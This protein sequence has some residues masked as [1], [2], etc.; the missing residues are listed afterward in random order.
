MLMIAYMKRHEPAYRFA[1]RM[2]TNVVFGNKVR[3]THD[4]HAE[5]LD[6]Y[7][8]G[9]LN[10][11]CSARRTWSTVTTPRSTPSPSRMRLT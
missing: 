2:Q 5:M 8:A 10:A 6:V 1:Q 4:E 3:H 9:E 7:A 11:A